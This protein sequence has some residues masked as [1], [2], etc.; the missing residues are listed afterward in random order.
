MPRGRNQTQ[1][2]ATID[3]HVRSRPPGLST[4]GL[5]HQLPPLPAIPPPLR[6][7]FPLP[8]R[9]EPAPR[10]E[11]LRSAYSEAFQCIASSCEDTCCQG[12]SIP[13]DQATYE[14]YTTTEMMQPHIG[15]LI[16]LNAK[17]ASSSDHAR[18]NLTEHGTCTFLDADKLCGVQKKLGPA[19]LSDT[20]SIYPRS[21]ST[22][23]GVVE[24]ALNLSC[25]EAARLTLLN[26][27]L[28]GPV[29]SNETDVER[30]APTLREA[31]ARQRPLQT[32]GAVEY[33]A[34]LAVRDYALAL[35]ADRR[36]PL[37]QRLFLLGSMT[38]RLQ[39]LA[40]KDSAWAYASSN[41][42]AVAEMLA[43][44]A[45]VVADGRMRSLMNEIDASIAEQLPLVLDIVR[46]RV[47]QPS[48]G[49]RFLECL[50]D[51]E[52][53]IGCA[54]AVSEKEIL[55][56]YREGYRSFY[57]PLMALH[58]H[59]L[60][61]DVTNYIFKNNYPFGRKAD[62]PSAPLQEAGEIL[63]AED[64]H[65]LLCVHLA[66]TQTLLS[67]IAA[68]WREQFGLEHVIKL[69]QSLARACEHSQLFLTETTNLVKERN[70]NNSRGVVLLLRQNE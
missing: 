64:E 46:L 31:D 29:F 14:K 59:I 69:T 39:T 38:R 42:G 4:N 51:F 43:E 33:D 58:P 45:Q 23:A 70:L 6:F 2:R 66:L 5:D 13:I 26:A 62:R 15:K 57:A 30:Y 37:W 50:A 7:P 63:D 68:R 24:K 44:A 49:A 47:A 27:S 55:D 25:P 12:W 65:M 56:L 40:G 34:R 53:G 18:M 1:G 9:I 8:G 16:V 28:L 17:A 61:N 19:M 22:R 60:E 67:G 20:C 21:V 52:T 3:D 41:P 48:V 54:S 10:R 32:A 11:Y 36:Y 35:V